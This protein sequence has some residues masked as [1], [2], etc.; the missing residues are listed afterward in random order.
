MKRSRTA[1]L[2]AMGATPLLLSACNNEPDATRSGL[3]TSVEACTAA[4]HDVAT[5][6]DAYLKA[7][8]E[9]EAEAPHYATAAT[10]EADF[11]LDQCIQRGSGQHSFYGP[12]M[13]GFFL[14]QMMHHGR[15]ANGFNS[16]PAFR[17]RW[18]SWRRPADDKRPD[19]PAGGSYGGS[20]YAGGS[21][22][23]VYRSGTGRSMTRVSA[24]PDRAITVSRGGFGRSGGSHGFH[25][26]HGFGG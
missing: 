13:T 7:H 6:S 25:G 3:Y 1:V 9:A 24:T 19:N 10:C 18:N 26:F 11:G 17:D 5:C 15:A 2:L 21:Y 23:G 4:T 20:G 8:Q 16:A 22:G 12:L 14:S